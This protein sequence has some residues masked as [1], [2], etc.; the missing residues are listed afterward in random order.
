[1]SL[2]TFS[3]FFTSRKKT[4]DLFGYGSTYHRD[5]RRVATG[6]EGGVMISDDFDYRYWNDNES[7]RESDRNRSW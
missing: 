4:F 5:D 1:M 6:K 3:I 7:Q 2:E